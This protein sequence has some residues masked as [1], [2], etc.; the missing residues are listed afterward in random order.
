MAQTAADIDTLLTNLRARIASIEDG[1]ASY[2]AAQRSVSNHNLTTLYE[3]ERELMRRR[4]QIGGSGP[5]V[6]SEV[7]SSEAE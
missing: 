4:A 5:L 7:G 2:T 6:I 3:R 1:M